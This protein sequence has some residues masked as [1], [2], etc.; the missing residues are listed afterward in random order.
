[1]ENISLNNKP[2][3]IFALK[4]YTRSG[5]FALDTTSLYESY[6]DAIEYVR[7]SK[8]V[9]PSQVI[10]VDDKLRKITKVYKVSYNPAYKANSENEIEKYKYTLDE[11]SI[12]NESIG[13]INFKGKLDSY[14]DLPS[15]SDV[16]DHDMYYVYD[17]DSDTYI[18]YVYVDGSWIKVDFGINY[19]SKNSDGIITKEL[20]QNLMGQ[21]GPG[22]FYNPGQIA[23]EE[24]QGRGAKA[25]DSIFIN[26]KP[27][28]DND[29]LTILTEDKM[30]ESIYSIMESKPPYIDVKYNYDLTEGII[31]SEYLSPTVKITYYPNLGGKIKQVVI[32]S[33]LFEPFVLDSKIF[34]EIYRDPSDENSIIDRYESD[35]IELP[36]FKISSLKSVDNKFW[37]NLYYDENKNTLY[38]SGNASSEIDMQ[39]YDKFQYRYGYW[40]DLGYIYTDFHQNDAN[41]AKENE[42]INIHLEDS[43]NGISIFEIKTPVNIKNIEYIQQN[44]NAFLEKMKLTEITESNGEIKYYLYTWEGYK[45]YPIKGKMDFI[46][47]L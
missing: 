5:Q 45:K 35:L 24:Q 1:M 42:I 38:P 46:V 25:E 23:I 16:K 18:S 8:V 33:T 22:I 36:N 21:T 34:K 37:I 17:K 26:L 39:V 19:A 43:A 3:P 6:A 44:N 41:K 30:K 20:Y 28:G 10:S 13:I 4:G 31:G 14:D 11:I 40:K 29:S 9:Y 27:I 32:G 2:K 15:G 47:K 12:G 7:T